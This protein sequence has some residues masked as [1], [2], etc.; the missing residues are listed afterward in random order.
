MVSHQASQAALAATLSDQLPIAW[1]SL[2]INNLEATTP[3]FVQQVAAL[4]QQFGK[5]SAAIA[6]Q[7][8]VLRRREAG[9]GGRVNVRP[10]KPPAIGAVDTGVRWAIKG[11]YSKEPDVASA[12]TLVQGVAERGVLDTG[13]NTLLDAIANDKRAKGWARET[14]PGACSF[15]LL[16]AVR[17]AVYREHSFTNAN[18]KFSGP[19]AFKSHNS[20]RCNLVPVF[21]VFEPSAQLRRWQALYAQAAQSASG[22]SQTRAT[23]RQLVEADRK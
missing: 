6:A 12:K 7:N 11:L 21:G 19:G 5:A 22:P 15:C 17:G 23:F 3:S 4:V 8:Y 18:F 20:C 13:R 16:L 10:A 1:D 9:I 14:E 2:E